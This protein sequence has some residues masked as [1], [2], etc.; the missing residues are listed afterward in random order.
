MIFMHIHKTPVNSD[1]QIHYFCHFAYITVTPTRW[2]LMMFQTCDSTKILQQII[3]KLWLYSYSTTESKFD[4][5]H[6]FFKI[7]LTSSV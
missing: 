1:Y 7:S 4:L 6:L 3:V 2:I 5:N